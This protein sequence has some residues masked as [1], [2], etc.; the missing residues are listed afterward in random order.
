MLDTSITSAVRATRMQHECNTS[1][2][3]LQHKGDTSVTRLK[4]IDFDNDPI[5]NIFSDPYIYHMA[6]ER[7][8][9]E[10]QFHSKKY[11]LEMPHSHA[12][13]HHKS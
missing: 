13:L 11:L 7:L 2:T 12:K 8:E 1:A 5:K 9:G 6:S 10:E 3:R 4:K